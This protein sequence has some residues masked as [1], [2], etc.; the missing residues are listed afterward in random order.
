MLECVDLSEELHRVVSLFSTYLQSQSVGTQQLVLRGILQLSKR[1]DTVSRSSS[2]PIP[3]R[4][5]ALGLCRTALPA[6]TPR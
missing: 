3:S 2:L 5:T 4:P 6:S 1:Q